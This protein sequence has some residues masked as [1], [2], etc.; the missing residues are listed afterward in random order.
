M[1][2]HLFFCQQKSSYQVRII[3]LFKPFNGNS[4]PGYGY[5]SIDHCSAELGRFT[6]K[7]HIPAHHRDGLHCF[8]GVVGEIKAGPAIFWVYRHLG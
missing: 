4:A 6:G 2:D 5:L 3:D 8:G 7:S 1:G